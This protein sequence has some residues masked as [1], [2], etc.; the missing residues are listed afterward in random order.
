MLYGI[1]G[2]LGG[3]VAGVCLFAYAPPYSW[4][5]DVSLSLFGTNVVAISF[6]L[7]FV[8]TSTPFALLARVIEPRVDPTGALA[9][10][11][12]RFDR[13]L[14]TGAG[15]LLMIGL[16]IVGVSGYLGAR[17]AARGPLA[18]VDVRALERGEGP[19]HAYA[20]LEHA[21]LV[22]EGQIEFR[23]GSSSSFFVPIVSSGARSSAAVFAHYRA[24]IDRAAPL[25]GTLDQD[26]LPGEIRSSYEQAH[27]IDAPHWVLDVGADPADRMSVSMWMGGI[28]FALALAAMGWAIAARRALPR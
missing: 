27:V 6:L 22:D 15:K 8:V 16:T 25:R 14:D 9:L 5:A 24:G 20:D 19:A 1:A 10:K 21:T 13:F 28:G 12:D 11:W 18:S 3:V 7:T 4:A 2:L 23:D 17:D 26:D